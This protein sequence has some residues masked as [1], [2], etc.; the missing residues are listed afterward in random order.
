M[1]TTAAHRRARSRRPF[2]APV[3]GSRASA[4]ASRAVRAAN[5]SDQTGA[6][7]IRAD[8]RSDDLDLLDVDAEGRRRAPCPAA[9]PGRPSPAVR[10]MRRRPEPSGRSPSARGGRLGPWRTTSSRLQSTRT[11]APVSAES[12][13]ARSATGLWRLPP[14]APPLAN[15][16]AGA[17]PGRHQLASGST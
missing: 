15:G 9:R 13:R 1:V 12:A 8:R 3:P 7:Q 14:K 2:R 6:P 4:R 11:A 5:T 17:A 16:V 10:P